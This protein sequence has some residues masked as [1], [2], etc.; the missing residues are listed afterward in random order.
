MKVELALIKTKSDYEKAL[1]RIRPLMRKGD[2]ISDDELCELRALGALIEAYENEHYPW[3][4]ENITARDVVLSVMKERGLRQCDLVPYFGSKSA[5]S[6]FINGKRGIP[7]SAIRGFSRA[8]H[9]PTEL[10]L[11]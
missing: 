2:E 11:A 3:K 10:L 5:V 6:L 7:V 1:D 4:D 8:F 9:V